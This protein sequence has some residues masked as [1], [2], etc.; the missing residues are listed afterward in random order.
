MYT[1]HGKAKMVVQLHLS[2]ISIKLGSFARYIHLHSNSIQ[3]NPL[4]LPVGTW[5]R[6]RWVL[7]PEGMWCPLFCWW[8]PQPD[9]KN[10]WCLV[11]P[12]WGHWW[13]SCS[14]WAHRR[15]SLGQIWGL[16]SK[17]RHVTGGGDDLGAGQGG[18]GSVTIN[19]VVECCIKC[20]CLLCTH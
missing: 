4:W 14:R 5:G 2:S 9:P 18:E 19:G 11:V 6:H 13:W 17:L 16:R 3:D 8:S 12:E 1:D 20:L 10:W 15:W 7:K